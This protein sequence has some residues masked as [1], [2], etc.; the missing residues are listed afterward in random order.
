MVSVTTFE[1]HNC[2]VINK[3]EEDIL[4]QLLLVSKLSTPN[5]KD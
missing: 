3:A 2:N 4:K 5:L 1:E